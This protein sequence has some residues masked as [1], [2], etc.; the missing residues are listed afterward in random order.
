MVAQPHN[1]ISQLLLELSSQQAN[2][3]FWVMRNMVKIRESHG[4]EPTA[5]LFVV[6]VVVV[7][8]KLTVTVN[9]AM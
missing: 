8:Q 1:V 6:V 2:P 7:V 3:L 9:V 4:H 5:L